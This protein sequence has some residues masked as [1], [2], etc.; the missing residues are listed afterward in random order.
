LLKNKYDMQEVLDTETIDHEP[1]NSEE[2]RSARQDVFETIELLENI[3]SFLPAEKIFNIQR[4]SKQWKAVIAASPSIEEKMFLRLKTAP[5]ETYEPHALGWRIS[6]LQYHRRPSA[7]TL[8]TL[9]HQ[10]RH[11]PI[12]SLRR[13]GLTC[14]GHER[15][16]MV[17]W[18]PAPIRQCHSLFDTYICDPPSKRAEVCLTV[19]FKKEVRGASDSDT[20][21][22]TKIWVSNVTAKSESGLTFQDV[23]RA[24]LNAHGQTECKDDFNF[25]S[26]LQHP[27]ELDM[28]RY[29]TFSWA[30]ND[31]LKEAINRLPE[32]SKIPEIL[33]CALMVLKLTLLD[34]VAAPTPEERALLR[35]ES[36]A[37]IVTGR[38]ESKRHG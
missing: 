29:K 33:D 3:V 12:C 1:K 16:V 20:K 15:R 37:K 21:Y 14:A 8:V 18:G 10:L 4:V 22:P 19:S 34:D 5:K 27:S 28:L 2:A 30:H 17:Q 7:F 9:N 23:L 6:A 26:E 36:A 13:W 35:Q 31:S 38:S 32:Y 24:A 11:D 25:P